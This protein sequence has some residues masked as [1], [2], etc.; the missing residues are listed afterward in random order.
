MSALHAFSQ[1]PEDAV[2]YSWLPV[3]GSARI[4][5]VGGVVGSLGGDISSVYGNPAGIGF[6]NTREVVLSLNWLS[7]QMNA[8]YREEKSKS[9]NNTMLLSPVG[10][11]I[12][13]GTN[14]EKTQL[15]TIAFSLNQT[16]NFNARYSYKGLNN[17]SS[18]TE[19]LA[20]EFAGSGY[21]INDVLQTNSSMPYTAAPALYTYLIDT[22]LQ[23]DGSY[24]VTGAPE[25][26]L[27][28]GQAIMQ[29]FY[30]KSSG[31]IYELAGTYAL[32]KNDRFYFGGTIGIPIIHYSSTTT[33]RESDTSSV[34]NGFTD[35][36]YEDHF[37]TT[38]AGINLKLGAI[39]RPKDY[40]RIGLALHSPTFMFLTDKRHTFINTNLDGSTYSVS[41]NTFTLGEPGKTTYM[42]SSPWKAIV[43]GS[44]V[45]REVQNTKKQ[46]GFISADIEYIHHR[47]STFSSTKEDVTKEE[48]QYYKDL[49]RV[50]KDNFKGAFNF[51]VGGELKF[52]VIMARLGFAYYG[53]PYR[54]NPEKAYQMQLAGGIG[55]RNHG[56]F[57]DLGYVHHVVRNQE[58]PY[59]LL[60]RA[61]TYA[62]LKNTRGQVVATV[63]FKF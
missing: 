32:N 58:F 22:V 42:Q 20:E 19:Q 24:L 56:I 28:N 33:V 16:A 48:K 23:T 9:Q 45:F 41:S 40:V 3:N 5:S 37:K 30:K 8:T 49:T 7:Q 44:F 60:D 25:S 18:F 31:G 36:T 34:V 57:I 55:Y 46:R 43:S 21:S 15:S 26:I 53:N 13:L 63:G 10:V 12:G 47:G 4:N 35:F 17:Y 1:V 61:N 27:D 52:D 14:Y 51:R 6:F 54:Y 62:G 11:V 59:R 38:G 29:E 2:R 39:Y 50:V